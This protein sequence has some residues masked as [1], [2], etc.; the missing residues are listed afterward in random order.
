MGYLVAPAF[1]LSLARAARG[2][3]S[4]GHLVVAGYV[5]SGLA[6]LGLLTLTPTSPV[7]GLSQRLIEF[8]VLAWAVL[9]GRYLAKQCASGA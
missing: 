5:A 2:W 7:A 3:P 9:C 8:A 1:M 4:A 6:L